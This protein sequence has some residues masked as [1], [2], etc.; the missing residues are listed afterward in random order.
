MSMR[1]NSVSTQLTSISAPA[2]PNRST[3][4]FPPSESISQVVELSSSAGSNPPRSDSPDPVVEADATTPGRKD[5][6]SGLRRTSSLRSSVSSAA[7]GSLGARKR[8]EPMFNLAVHNVVHSTVVTDAATDVKVAKV[9]QPS[10]IRADSCSFS[11]APSMSL[12]WVY[13]N[14]QKY[15]YQS[16]I[17]PLPP[18]SLLQ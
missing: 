5:L 8:V 17:L 1:S 7:S 11:N 9:G 13:L 3:I 10:S 16:P 12:V 18:I 2:S 6:G 4:D 14:H 15:G